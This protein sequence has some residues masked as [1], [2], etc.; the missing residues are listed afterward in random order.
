M[1]IGQLV[2]I[3]IEI[4]FLGIK[5]LFLLVKWNVFF[6]FY[7]ESIY[8]MHLLGY[9]IRNKW[10]IHFVISCSSASELYQSKVRQR[11][12]FMRLTT[13]KNVLRRSASWTRVNQQCRCKHVKD[14]GHFG[15]CTEGVYKY[16]GAKT[17][18][19]C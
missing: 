19:L 2:T 8:C 11:T 5:I 9:L 10:G 12:M 4:L 16:V 3:K 1:H 14:E 17:T 18:H 7:Q 15:N 6:L 13:V